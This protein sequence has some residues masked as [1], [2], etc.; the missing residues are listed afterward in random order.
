MEQIHTRDRKNNTRVRD[1]NLLEGVIPKNVSVIPDSSVEAL[2]FLKCKKCHRK[3]FCSPACQLFSEYAEKIITLEHRV[4]RGQVNWK[5]LTE[6]ES[7]VMDR[8]IYHW[9]HSA[10]TV[11]HGP[12]QMALGMIYEY[13]YGVEQDDEEALKWYQMSADQKLIEGQTRVARM[14]RDGRGTKRPNDKKALQV[15]RDA[16]RGGD[17]EAFYNIGKLYQSGRAGLVPDDRKTVSL[18]K[19]STK[20]DRDYMRSQTSMGLVYLKGI[21]GTEKDFDEAARLFSSAAHQGY[22]RA[23][24]NLGLLHEKGIGVSQD[25]VCASMWWSKAAAQGHAPSQHNLALRYMQGRRNQW[26]PQDDVGAVLLFRKAASQLHGASFTCLA[27][28]YEHG[29][30]GCEV[31]E[32]KAI[33]LCHEALDEGYEPARRHLERLRTRKIYREFEDEEEGCEEEDVNWD[34]F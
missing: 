9:K 25:L 1:R 19:T 26:L 29:I 33:E 7:R 8:I 31:D 21:A 12:S 14:M 6:R 20:L 15:F 32:I 11:F 30:G 16:A 23:Q 27:L 17:A 10:T 24:Y 13:G 4:L 18:I 5:K 34:G 3:R 28:C 2:R 22:A